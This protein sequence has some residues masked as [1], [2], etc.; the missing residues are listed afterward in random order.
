M[1][2]WAVNTPFAQ[3]ETPGFPRAFFIIH[4]SLRLSMAKAEPPLEMVIHN[5]AGIEHVHRI[6]L[7]MFR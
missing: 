1:Y 3:R 2:S 5:K 6:Y 7:D 4:I